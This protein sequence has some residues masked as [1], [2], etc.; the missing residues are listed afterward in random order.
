M[1]EKISSGFKN[2]L[3]KVN[4][5]N[6][7]QGNLPKNFEQKI[8]SFWE[9]IPINLT[10]SGYLFQTKNRKSFPREKNSLATVENF[11]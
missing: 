4:R 5:K 1:T 8:F 2:F 7:H 10:F 6:D 3:V 11:F 9:K